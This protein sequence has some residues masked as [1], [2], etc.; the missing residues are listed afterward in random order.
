V[1]S[2]ADLLDNAKITWKTYVEHGGNQWNAASYISH[3]RYGS[4]WSKNVKTKTGQFAT[5]AA[6]CTSDATCPNFPQVMW[7]NTGAP[8]SEHPSDTI[9]DSMAWTQ[10][11]VN[12]VMTNPYL[13]QHSAIFIT[14]DDWGGLYDHRV[15]TFDSLQLTTGLRSPCYA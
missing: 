15:P 6:G 10:G 1:T 3:I 2:I 7:V 8:Y 13:W 11:I 9:S 12:A 5:D 14:W 4:D